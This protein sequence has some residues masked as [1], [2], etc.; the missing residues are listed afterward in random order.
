MTLKIAC[1]H[2]G[3][4]EDVNID[5]SVTAAAALI[6]DMTECVAC[7]IKVDEYRADSRL[8]GI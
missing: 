2:C 4:E 7:L 8:A 5:G 3:V 6:M 1:V